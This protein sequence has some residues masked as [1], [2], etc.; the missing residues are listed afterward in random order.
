MNTILHSAGPVSELAPSAALASEPGSE[1]KPALKTRERL[2]E[3][4]SADAALDAFLRL[5]Q[6]AIVA[7][8][9]RL[10]LDISVNDFSELLDRADEVA[11]FKIG[12]EVA[13]A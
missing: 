2:H 8:V 10:R 7:G 4:L 1:K 11:D 3:L 5:L 13:A 12:A 6:P 9:A